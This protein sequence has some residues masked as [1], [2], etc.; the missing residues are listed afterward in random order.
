ME[1][2]EQLRQEYL[3]ALEA[4]VQQLKNSEAG[5]R[6]NG[7]KEGYVREKVKIN[8]VEIFQK[9]F[10]VSFHNIYVKRE[11]PNFAQYEEAYAK[12][13][14]QLC[15]AYLAYFEKIPGPWREKA[16]KDRRFGRM[17]EYETEQLKLQAAGQVQALFMEHFNRLFNGGSS[18]D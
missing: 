12:K 6:Q 8:V 9:M 5:C 1:K 13:E 2:H 11:I 17:A 18:H 7:D 16:E 4:Y 10:T 3:L 14:N 15:A